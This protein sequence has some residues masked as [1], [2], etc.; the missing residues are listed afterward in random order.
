MTAVLVISSFVV[1]GGVGLRAAFALE[2]LGHRV[3]SVPTVI[4]PH[5]PGHG[6]GTRIVTADFA[7]LLADLE[8]ARWLPEIGAVIS[9]YLGEAAQAGPIA[10]LVGAVK[11][12]NPDA[13]YV[14]DPVC[15]DGGGLYVPEA[16]AAAIRDTLIPIAD[17]ATPNCTE[18]AFLTGRTVDEPAAMVAAA[19]ALGPATVLVTSAPALMRNS[20]ATAL[21]TADSAFVAEHPVIAGSPNGPG[22]LFAAL[23]TAR[24]LEGLAPE[25]TLSGAAAGTFEMLA[26]SVRAG[27]DEL[28]LA[29][30]QDVL[31]RP[32]ATVAVRRL[33]M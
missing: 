26:R 17:V 15:G 11:A 27:A 5:H 6:R 9:G 13:F 28:L 19:R 14:C 25:A 33:A 4:L 18:L 3:W 29:A 7:A 20:V 32:A 23:Y 24:R 2:R 31:V 1:R 16:T 21:V 22:D 30:E 12:A 8:K 10:S